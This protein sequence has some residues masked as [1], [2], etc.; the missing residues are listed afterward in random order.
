M[1]RC[2]FSLLVVSIWLLASSDPAQA[3]QIRAE[4]GGVA[5]GR[6]VIQSTINIGVPPEQL[7]ALIR[8]HADLS[9]AQKK[10]IAKLEATSTSISVKSAPHWIFLVRK[11]FQPSGWRPSWSTL[12]SSSKN[13][14]RSLRFSPETMPR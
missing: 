8:Q 4:T 6:D 5:V 9:E 3:Q 14:G 2:F 10:L 11:T 7:A 1:K 12:R 13:F